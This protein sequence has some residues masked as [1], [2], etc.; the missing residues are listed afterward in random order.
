MGTYIH[1]VIELNVAVEDTDDLICTMCLEDLRVSPDTNDGEKNPSQVPVQLPIHPRPEATAAEE[2]NEQEQT[3]NNNENQDLGF[4][5]NLPDD[6][7]YT[8]DDDDLAIVRLPPCA[9]LFHAKC[10]LGWF[11]SASP[12]R[13]KCPNCRVVLCQMIVLTIQQE[14]DRRMEIEH[15][16]RLS[17]RVGWLIFLNDVD[18][19]FADQIERP[20]DEADYTRIPHAV[21]DTFQRDSPNRIIN[22]V[23]E[24][25]GPR[26]IELMASRRAREL[27]IE[28]QLSNSWS[29]Q[30]FFGLWIAL[31]RAYEER[32]PEL[33]IPAPLPAPSNG[34]VTAPATAVPVPV[35]V[36]QSMQPEEEEMPDEE[37]FTITDAN[38]NQ[39]LMQM[40]LFNSNDE[41]DILDHDELVSSATERQPPRNPSSDIIANPDSMLREQEQLLEE[42]QMV[43]EALGEESDHLSEPVSDTMDEVNIASQD[44]HKEKK[45]RETMNIQDDA[46]ADSPKDTD[47]TVEANPLEPT[48]P[49]PVPN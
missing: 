44:E 26:W 1:S 3:G 9:H 28:Y 27:I 33:V 45:S 49:N 2:Q 13:N 32:Y 5:Y 24:L 6:P 31:E 21:R 11:N 36:P 7:N 38:G 25:A 18:N 37:T 34:P 10:I 17:T 39:V 30:Q 20:E 8:T 15:Y 19:A 47:T 40:D 46:E 43:R 35:P 4:P 12:N 29:G 14:A 42:V 16:D 41:D 48:Q 22:S 23:H